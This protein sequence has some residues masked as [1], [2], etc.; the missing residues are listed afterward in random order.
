VN[1][2]Q[3]T[4]DQHLDTK[5]LL[6]ITFKPGICREVAVAIAAAFQAAPGAVLWSDE[7]TLPELRPEDVNA[8]GLSWRRLAKAGI[9]QRLEGQTDHRRSTSKARKGGVVWRYRIASHSLLRAF[10]KA[11]GAPAPAAKQLQL[12]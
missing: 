7:V 8:V 4:V 1:E 11:N 9:I 10:L 2:P 5:S 12:V 6:Q 3:P